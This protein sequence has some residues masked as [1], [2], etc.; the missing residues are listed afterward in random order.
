MDIPLNISKALT[1]SLLMELP[2]QEQGTLRGLLHQDGAKKKLLSLVVLEGEEEEDRRRR[3]GGGE[4]RSPS[5]F[6]VT[7]HITSL[8][9]EPQAT[10]LPP[11]P[12]LV[13]HQRTYAICS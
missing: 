11:D 6:S 13:M 3:I 10:T 1:T 12:S 4:R 9:K 2:S 8:S 7:S 5:S